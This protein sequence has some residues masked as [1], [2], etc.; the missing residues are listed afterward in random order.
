MEKFS[1]IW[2]HLQKAVGWETTAIQKDMNAHLLL[3]FDQTLVE[4]PL[5]RT[6]QIINQNFILQINLN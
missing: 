5:K 1:V 4:N 3:E 6:K 2:E